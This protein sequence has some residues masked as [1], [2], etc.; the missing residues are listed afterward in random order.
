MSTTFARK[1]NLLCITG[2]VFVLTI[3][4]CSTEAKQRSLQVK[5]EI[6]LALLYPFPEKNI[7]DITDI[8]QLTPFVGAFELARQAVLNASSLLP[9]ISLPLI[10][11]DTKWSSSVALRAL[12]EQWRSGADAFIG[13][14]NYQGFCNTSARLAAAWNLP[15]VS[16]VSSLM[17]ELP[18]N[19]LV[20]SDKIFNCQ[21]F[22]SYSFN[23]F[24]RCKAND[25]IKSFLAWIG[26]K[27]DFAFLGKFICCTKV[28]KNIFG[29]FSDFAR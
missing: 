7:T 20:P 12:T 13:P 1:L 2:V 28:N 27:T 18:E 5:T 23:L 6:R 10:W 26:Y 25:D 16:Y 8:L 29:N 22:L 24:E 21:L 3:S 14:G 17:L 19:V 11:N 15:L 9:S 4:P